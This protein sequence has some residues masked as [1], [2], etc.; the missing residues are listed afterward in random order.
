MSSVRLTDEKGHALGNGAVREGSGRRK[1]G[2]GT[3]RGG[4][5][6]DIEVVWERRRRRRK[7]SLETE[8]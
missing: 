4:G 5:R 2:A 8:A 7:G 3:G 6:E 1:K